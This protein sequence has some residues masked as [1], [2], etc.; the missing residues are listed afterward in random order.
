MKFKII[1]IL[2]IG[3]FFS[4]KKKKQQPKKIEE[5]IT[6]KT[7]EKREKSRNSK[8]YFYTVANRLSL[9]KKPSLAAKRIAVLKYLEPLEI[10]ENFPNKKETISDKKDGI[11]RGNWCKVRLLNGIEGYAFNGY[12]KSF[13][14][15]PQKLN[16]KGIEPNELLINGKLKTTTSLKYFLDIIGKPDSIMSY[17]LSKKNDFSDKIEREDRDGILYILQNI[18]AFTD[19]NNGDF[20]D[21]GY[22]GWV[23]NNIRMKYFYKNGIEYEELNGEVSFSNIDFA[24]NNNFIT[25][26]R[27]IALQH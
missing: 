9:R 2:I 22:G 21:A 3:L 13:E 24:I 20:L 25:Y 27:L 23:Y 6:S 11:V 19:A 5:A 12:I 7:V 14:E 26:I 18:N 8:E 4:C 1:I 17:E 16:P 10:I 15:L